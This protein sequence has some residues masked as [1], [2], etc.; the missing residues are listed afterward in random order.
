M[1]SG[2][3]ISARERRDAAESLAPVK[4]FG[5]LPSDR[6]YRLGRARFPVM[7]EE[8]A[9]VASELSAPPLVLD[10]G[11]GQAKL[12][13]VYQHEHPSLP[14]RW[15]GLDLLRMRLELRP[16]VPDMV[17]VQGDVCA[18]PFASS[19][20][21]V[22]ASSYV[23][24]HLA[25]P[26]AALGEFSR[27]LRPGG[28]LLLGVPNRPQPL[29]LLAELLHP[30]WVEHR[31]RRGKEHAYLPQIQFYDR[32]RLARLVRGAGLRPRRWQGL[33]FVTGGPL[34]FLENYAW[35]YRANL[36][37]GGVLPGLARD[38]VCVAEKPPAGG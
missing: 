27:V 18:L 1:S 2:D 26:G 23:L 15:V 4:A 13:R 33:G 24:Q 16:D 10:A 19:C 6:R 35:Y 20:F 14:A 28:V 38:L 25:D 32:P 5:V 12:E 34:R 29:K 37:A 22:V 31:R 3:E 8:L 21:D 36:W 9:R 11:V 17:Q 7:A 30:H